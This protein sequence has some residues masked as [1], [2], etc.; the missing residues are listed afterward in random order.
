MSTTRSRESLFAGSRQSNGRNINDTSNAEQSRNLSE[1]QNNEQIDH[2]SLQ[3]TQLKQLTTNIHGEVVSQ[4]KFLDGMGSDFDNADGLLGGTLKKIGSMMEHGG[5]N[6][7]CM[8]IVF[9]VVI[10]VILYYIIR[11]Y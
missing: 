7:M 10:F 9:V 1:E 3:I 5:S 4:N 11:G 6:H 8:L 2:L